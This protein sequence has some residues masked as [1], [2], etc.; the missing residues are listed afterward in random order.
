[1]GTCVN[2]TDG[3]STGVNLTD[4][5]GDGLVTVGPF[6]PGPGW[7]VCYSFN[8]QEYQVV[9]FGGAVGWA[10]DPSP[11]YPEADFDL[12]VTGASLSVLDKFA[13]VPGDA[14]GCAPATSGDARPYNLTAP[15]VAPSR[16][17]VN[18]TAG[19]ALS[20]G[21]YTVCYA[22]DATR[23]VS[24]GH[25]LT[26]GGA[27]GFASTPSFPKQ[28][29]GFTL[30]LDGYLFGEGDRWAVVPQSEGCAVAAEARARNVSG[31]TFAMD[32][33]NVTSYTV[34]ADGQDAGYH[35]VCYDFQGSGWLK[36]GTTLRIDGI[37][38]VL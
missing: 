32:A 10:S 29:T 37:Y 33:Y 17:R 15:D 35:D 14:V 12:V 31:A 23:F 28:Y 13:F 11:P 3:T 24:I 34:A 5:S 30:R 21:M 20:A 8:G 7:A 16:A 6:T 18:V 38:C 4:I 22:V 36:V 9:D 19:T 2:V 27:T 25:T 1:M 26:V